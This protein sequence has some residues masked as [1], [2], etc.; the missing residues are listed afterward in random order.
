MILRKFSTSLIYL[1]FITAFSFLL[2]TQIPGDPAEMIANIGRAEPATQEM[3]EKV[4]MEYALDRPIPEQ[5]LNWLARV[6]LHGDFGKSFRTAVPVSSEIRN[7][8][9]AT[10]QLACWTFLFTI[11]ISLPLGIFSAISRSRLAD[12]IIQLCALLGY[13]VPVFLVGNLFLWIFSVKLGWLPAIGRSSWRHVILPVATLS[14]HLIGWATQVVRSS[15][16]EHLGQYYVL[17]A[18]AKGLPR[19]LI[20]QRYVL[21]P[22]LIPILTMFLIMLGQLVSGSFM[23]EV[24]FAWNGLGKLLIDAVMAR[25]Y[26]MIQGL[27]FFI[28]AVFVSINFL[29]DVLYVRLNPQIASQMQGNAA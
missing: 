23:I 4:R 21:R 13:A 11:G 14:I 10:L 26:P 16:K 29:I 22:A 17:V 7:S 20:L 28:G 12:Q 18:Q 3:I 25:D 9:P 2:S 5:Y 8:L 15:V 24:V 6:V 19:R 1:F 27:I